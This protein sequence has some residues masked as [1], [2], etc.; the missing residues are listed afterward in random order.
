MKKHLRTSVA[1]AIAAGGMSAAMAI[2]L[3]ENISFI[4]FGTAGFARSNRSEAEFRPSVF[5]KRGADNSG[6]DFGVDSKLGLQLNGKVNSQFSTSVQVLAQR[7]G[8]TSNADAISM[9]FVKWQPNSDLAVRVGRLRWA[10]FLAT[11]SFAVGYANPWV[12]PPVD[13]YG[14]VPMYTIDGIDATYQLNWG[15]NALS[16][17]PMYG[18][19]RFD[20]PEPFPGAGKVNGK[21]SNL[22]G[23][24]MVLER[25]PWT[26]RAG[27]NRTKLTVSN[28]M[29]DSVFSGLRMASATMPEAG[30]LADSLEARGSRGQFMGA[31]V[32]YSEGNVLLQGE[33]TLRRTKSFMAD[34]TGWY[35]TAGYRF[36]KV[37]PYFTLARLRVDSP[38]TNNTLPNSGGT[39]M[40]AQGVNMLLATGNNG[41]QTASVG[42]RYDFAKNMALKVQFD[43][44]RLRGAGSTGFLVNAQP[45]FGGPVNVV[46]A[47]VDF[48]F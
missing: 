25:G 18:T 1:A 38:V 5:P 8:E 20:L 41:Q 34:T 37:M 44:I 22:V 15:D 48:V 47:V 46:S 27:Y 40:L 3:T 45:G 16:I 30:T 31:G 4:G 32:I 14:Q 42:T 35:G 17:Q 23:I 7:A 10:A 24:N 13:V 28:G 26:V 33:Y 21:S 43:H 19:T 39:A 9:A 2:D 11:E 29:I 12:R 36:G 6:L